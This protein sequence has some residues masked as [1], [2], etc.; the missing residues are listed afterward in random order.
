MS[1]RFSDRWSVLVAGGSQLLGVGGFFCLAIVFF[2]LMAPNFLTTTNMVNVLSAVSV[3]GVVAIGQTFVL[4]SGGFDLSVSGTLPLGGIVFTVAVN[5]G[6]PV[7]VAMLV[8]VL[9]GVLVGGFNAFVVTKVGINPLITTLATWQV[10]LGLGFVVSGGLTI[11]V[12][13]PSAGPLASRVGGMPLFV[14]VLL[15]L[16]TSAWFVL[17]FTTFGRRIYTLG[18]NPEAA[19]LAG[20]RTARL[21]ASVYV[22]SGAAASFAG[23]ILAQQ[24]L[25]GAPTVGG[26]AALLSITAVILG[27]AALTGGTGGIPGTILGVLLLGVVANGMAIMQVPSFYQTIATGFMLLLAV[28]LGRIRMVVERTALMARSA[29]PAPLSSDESLGG[30]PST[31]AHDETTERNA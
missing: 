30:P 7:P 16:A 11:P 5:A 22:L 19:R 6:Q 13:N 4:I 10:F 9:V 21:T 20:L 31:G 12:Q 24:L 29:P 14:W 23:V 2:A 15:F 27:G 25:A 8:A 26:D 17:R 3:L 18:G 1:D 28:G